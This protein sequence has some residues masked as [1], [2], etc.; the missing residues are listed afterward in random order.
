LFEI[1]K[2]ELFEVVAENVETGTKRSVPPIVRKLFS[3]FSTDKAFNEDIW[4]G[5]VPVRELEA[6]FSVVSLVNVPIELGIKP[7]NRLFCI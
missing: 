1:S 5:I 2:L 6:I 7:V 3:N 4:R